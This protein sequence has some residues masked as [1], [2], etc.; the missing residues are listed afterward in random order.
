MH[1]L[2][3][4]WYHFMQDCQPIIFLLDNRMCQACAATNLQEIRKECARNV[5]EIC[6]VCTKDAQGMC[7]ACV[8]NLQE[9]FMECS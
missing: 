1:V 2:V 3:D 4:I 7:K 9:I 5:R 6:K 8:R